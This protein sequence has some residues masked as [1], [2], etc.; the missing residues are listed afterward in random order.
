MAA[1]GDLVRDSIADIESFRPVST[2]WP[3]SIG[4]G[5]RLPSESVAGLRRRVSSVI[6]RKSASDEHR[7]IA[8]SLL[9]LKL[10]QDRAPEKDRAGCPI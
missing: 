4:M 9:D 2:G 8:G 5:G 10:C 6:R 1:K 3:A 7:Q